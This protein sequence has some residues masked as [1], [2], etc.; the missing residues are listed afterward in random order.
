[1]FT[2]VLPKKTRDVLA[3]IGKTKVSERFYL[4]GGT[5]AALQLGHRTSLDLDFFTATKFQSPELE[6]LEE[7]KEIGRVSKSS[8]SPGTLHCELDRVKLSFFRYGYPVLFPFQNLDNIKIADIR[9]IGL[10]KI[11]S[12][13]DRGSK[14]D[15]I[16]L[17][18]ISTEVLSLPKLFTFFRRKYKQVDYNV[19]HIIRSLAYFREAEKEK[20]MP[21][22]LRPVKWADVKKYFEKE[23]RE[24]WR[25]EA[26]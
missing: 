23:M 11:S 1:M 4:A 22:M 10:M 17:Y 19:I 20:K 16:D 5:G 25:E 21:K 12:V 7:L 26:S 15:F 24:L 13:S 9:D 8:T 2:S 6:L 14:K 3:K 18:F